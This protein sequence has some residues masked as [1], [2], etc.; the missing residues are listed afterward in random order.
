MARGM[1]EHALNPE[2]LDQWLEKTAEAQHST[3]C[4]KGNTELFRRGGSFG[5]VYNEGKDGWKLDFPSIHLATV[6]GFKGI[7]ACPTDAMGS[8]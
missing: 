5:R 8:Q 7:Q 3:S 1:M 2:Q 4:F 6:H